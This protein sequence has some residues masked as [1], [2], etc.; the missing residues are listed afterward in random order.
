MSKE[1]EGPGEEGRGLSEVDHDAAVS[2]RASMLLIS[3]EH[4]KHCLEHVS[5]F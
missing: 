5:H 2:A 3:V 4:L 1:S